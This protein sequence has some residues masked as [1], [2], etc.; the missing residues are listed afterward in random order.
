MGFVKRTTPVRSLAATVML[1]AI[2]AG[3]AAQA[4][5]R[6]ATT[7]D[8]LVTSPVFFH[9]K[10]VVVREDVTD[11]RGLA[12]L[13]SAPKPVYVFW[14]ERGAT[15]PNTEI[16]G[17]FWDLGRLEQNDPRFAGVDLASVLQAASQGQWPARDRL[18]VL[19]NATTAESPLP[20]DPTLRAI[21][22]APG[23]YAGRAVTIAGRFR[24]ANL[25]GDLPQPVNKSRWD[26]VLQ[27]ADAA[28][29]ITGMRPRGKGFDFDIGSRVD[30]R[31]WLDV[32]GTVRHEGALTWIEATSIAPGTAPTETPIEVTVPPMPRENP[33]QV[34]FT[35][36][37][38]NESD[39]EPTTVVRIQFSRDM[40]GK[41]FKDHV[42][43]SYAGNVPQGAPAQPPAMNVRYVEGTRALELKF[44]APLDRF[45]Q[46]RI[47][48]ADGIVSAVDNQPLAPY[49][50]TFMT[51][52]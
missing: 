35:A 32:A 4:P 43:A 28:L 31:R 24:G 38:A 34:I 11:D 45:R 52:G 17:E 8:A 51:G 22:L 36:P 26:F 1:W 23:H 48:L 10:Q 2:A 15:G 14:K 18:F 7:V 39:V 3:A 20:T 30:T 19:L 9:G 13:A 50:F 33:P 16:R 49:T 29:W 27:S 12:R 44:A 6:I 37:L 42:R 46:V 21:A 41:S 47:D 5:S 40:D 25:F